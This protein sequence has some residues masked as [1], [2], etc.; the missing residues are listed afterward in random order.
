M[1]PSALIYRSDLNPE[2][3]EPPTEAQATYH[4][5][6]ARCATKHFPTTTPQS[7]FLCGPRRAGLSVYN[8]F[9]QVRPAVANVRLG[10]RNCNSLERDQDHPHII[11]DK[12]LAIA[13]VAQR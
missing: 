11:T 8:V 1:R 10:P 13:S 12:T 6:L 7:L 9:K 5:F 4:A 3:L 2:E